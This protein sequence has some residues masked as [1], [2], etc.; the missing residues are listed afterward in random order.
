MMAAI[1]LT[2]C[3]DSQEALAETTQTVSDGQKGT[4][5]RDLTIQSTVLGREMKFS[6]YLP[7]G[8]TESTRTS[9]GSMTTWPTMP[10]R[11]RPLGKYPR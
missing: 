3:S 6:V 8:Y 11:W 5:V 2:A 9:G 4:V 1:L 7:A 10:M